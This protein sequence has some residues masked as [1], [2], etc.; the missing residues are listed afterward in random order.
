MTTKER[1]AKA[2]AVA[3]DTKVFEMGSNILHLAPSI[4][5]EQ[6]GDAKAIVIA[7]K[8]TWRVA[9]EEVYNYLVNAGIDTLK[10]IINKMSF[11][12]NGAM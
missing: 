5:K 12:P 7:D 10:H 4:F 2:L 1:I 11:M 6:F 8:N 9:G 3:T